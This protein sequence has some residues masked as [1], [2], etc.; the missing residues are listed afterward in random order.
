MALADVPVEW[1]EAC[2]GGDRVATERVLRRVSPDL[3]RIIFSMLRD[4]E[5]T[6]E[7]LQET[8]IRMFRH[9]GS[10][11]DP[12][13]FASWTMRVAVNQVQTWRVKRG[14][15]RL[16]PLA[17]GVEPEPGVVVMGSA[18]A[19]S[20]RQV[21][22]RNQTLRQI[23]A[24]MKELPARQQ[25]AITLFEIEGLMIREI[26]E[27]MDCSEGAVKFNLHEARKKLKRRLSRLFR[28]ERQRD[29]N[30]SASLPKKADLE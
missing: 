7:V 21:A 16:Y 12:E 28:S 1:I 20:P 25:M 27:A 3:F 15:D 23:E 11:R 6:N 9:I 22:E 2:R 18:L 4:P 26:A 24:A 14:R 13:R 29:F 5:E 10:L 30:V 17:E 8:L 19:P